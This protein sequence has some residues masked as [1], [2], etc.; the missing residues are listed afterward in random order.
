M[1]KISSPTH[2]DP[3]LRVWIRDFKGDADNAPKGDADM[4]PPLRLP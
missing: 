3:R 1:K 2:D 4:R